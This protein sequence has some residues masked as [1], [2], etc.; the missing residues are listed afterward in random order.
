MDGKFELLIGYLGNGITVWNTAAIEHGDYKKI[1]YI[2]IGG[3]I[4]LYEPEGKIPPVA[5]EKIERMASENKATFTKKFEKLPD[6]V[7]YEK[8]LM[9]VSDK[10]LIEYIR[11]KRPSEE[12]LPEL[13]EYFY[14]IS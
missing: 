7:Q 2:S 6:A 1:A 5:M 12:K 8:I 14:K 13:R 4:K 9:G 3:N 11:D 10:K